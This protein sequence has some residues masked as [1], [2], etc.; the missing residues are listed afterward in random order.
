MGSLIEV[1]H[2]PNSCLTWMSVE[3]HAAI[4]L[5]PFLV[6]TKTRESGIA[7]KCWQ[8]GHLDSF[9]TGLRNK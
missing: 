2:L 3:Q 4:T 8:A 6:I 9:S 5:T 1:Q 7:L